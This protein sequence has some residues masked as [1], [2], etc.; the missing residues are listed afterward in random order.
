MAEFAGEQVPGPSEEQ[1]TLWKV[2][3]YDM[4]QRRL[5]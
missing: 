4:S 3:S 1:R 5:A 2:L